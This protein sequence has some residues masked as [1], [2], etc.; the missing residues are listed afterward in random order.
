ML[1]G[2]PEL[3]VEL[4]RVVKGGFGEQSM[5]ELM[6]GAR[7]YYADV[8]LPK[9]VLLDPPIHLFGVSNMPVSK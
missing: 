8:A 1:W 5:K 6:E 7:A 4:I 2:S 9:L 3:V